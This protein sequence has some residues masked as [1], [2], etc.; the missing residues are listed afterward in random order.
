MKWKPKFIKIEKAKNIDEFIKNLKEIKEQV[1]KDKNLKNEL[2][3]N[4]N[5][6]QITELLDYFIAHPD[7]YLLMKDITIDEFIMNL[8]NKMMFKLGE[9]FGEALQKFAND[10]PFEVK[11]LTLQEVINIY[12]IW[13]FN[14]KTIGVD[15]LQKPK[16]PKRERM[17]PQKSWSCLLCG[18]EYKSRHIHLLCKQCKTILRELKLIAD[19]NN[20]LKVTK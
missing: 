10:E 12:I 18:E 3:E 19:G 2:S 11:E 4:L 5:I 13:R 16:K 14:I 6:S 9:Q 17:I 20:I 15:Y 7:L 8:M 1:K